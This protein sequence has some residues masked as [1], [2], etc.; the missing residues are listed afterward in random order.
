[1]ASEYANKLG[2]VDNHITGNFE[3]EQEP[4]CS[5][6]GVMRAIEEGFMFVG[7]F[8]GEI[9]GRKSNNFYLMPLCADGTQPSGGDGVSVLFCPWCGDQIV[10]HKRYPTG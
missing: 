2:M 5:C 1:M 9:S 7:N 8:V 10:G 3:W 6:G 4:S